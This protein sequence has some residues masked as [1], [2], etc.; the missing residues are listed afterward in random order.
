MRATPGAVL[1]AL[2]LAE[3]GGVAALVTVLPRVWAPPEPL[4]VSLDIAGLGQEVGAVVTPGDNTEFVTR[5]LF[6]PTRR[7]P[8]PPPPPAQAVTEDV[9]ADIQLVGLYGSDG[10]LEGGA[11]VRHKGAV[12]R[13][14]L[15]HALNGWTLERIEGRKLFF[16]ANGVSRDVLLK[17]S[18]QGRPASAAPKAPLQGGNQVSAVEGGDQKPASGPTAGEPQAAPATAPSTSP[19]TLS[20]EERNARLEEKRRQIREKMGR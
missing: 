3:L 16:S 18:E 20:R 9:F 4:A 17:Y 19:A 8:P 2:L 11:I 1:L 12:K 14:G 10:G 5:P 6:W 15:G 7:P 13:I